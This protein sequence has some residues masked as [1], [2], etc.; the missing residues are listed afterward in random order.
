MGVGD[1]YIMLSAQLNADQSVKWGSDQSSSSRSGVS[2]RAQ[3]PQVQF[4]AVK[5]YIIILATVYILY[6]TLQ[7]PKFVVGTL[8]NGSVASHT[9]L[10]TL[11]PKHHPTIS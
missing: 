4:F 2:K 10:L 9:L 8:I 5:L 3:S 6:K 11:I 1:T 7:K